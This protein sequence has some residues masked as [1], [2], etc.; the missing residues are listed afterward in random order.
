MGNSCKRVKTDE[1]AKKHYEEN[2]NK[3]DEENVEQNKEE[4]NI[5]NENVSKEK[6]IVEKNNEIKKEE[7]KEKEKNE[8]K[9]KKEE[10]EEKKNIKIKEEKENPNNDVD[11]FSEDEST[12]NLKLEIT[13]KKIQ[14]QRNHT[15]ELYEY[16]NS[17]KLEKKKIAQTESKAPSNGKDI[18]FEEDII[19]PFH[20]SQNQPLEFKI[21]D[22]I[23]D[24]VISVTLGQ[25]VGSLR[26]TY[27]ETLESGIIFEVTAI[28]NDEL[29]KECVFN[30][31][32]SGA[33]VG[34]KLGYLITSLGNQYDP[35]NK[36]VYESEILEN[37]NLVK[38]NE[39][40]IPLN[41]LAADNNLDDNIIEIELKDVL[42]SIELGKY[43]NSINQLFVKDI[44]LD[45][46]G[47][48]K[49]KIVCRKK[50]FHSLLDYLE[51]DLHLATTIFID[52]SES[53]GA[54]CHHV[55]KNESIFEYLMRS[56]LDV[57]EPY[58]EDQ[59]FHIYGYGFKLKEP[60]KKEYDP[61]MFPLSQKPDYPSIS[62]KEISKLYNDFLK[63]I[64]FDKAKT[65]ID[66]IIKKFNGTIK[67]D[68]ENYDIRDYNILLI[69]AN[70]DIT[71]EK[72]FVKNAIFTSTLPISI[73]VVGL[74]KGPYT[75]IENIEQNFLNLVDDEGNKPQRKCIKFI[76][77]NK[78]Q[79]NV[80]ST[81]K[82]S[83]IDIPEEMIEYL[84]IKNIEPSM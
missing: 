34:M 23:E 62:I 46:T 59:F 21:K 4:K 65:N 9:E 53:G 83:L 72:E 60:K 14:N 82:N 44:D 12:C 11:N 10:K 51:R 16:K 37:N 32:I 18:T 58:N 45:L 52:F 57:L 28:L 61:Y 27:R 42:H 56:F 49:A 17:R 24:T 41:Q 13:L 31:E 40:V 3:Y 73:I 30:V 7:K 38:F 69:F 71:D 5:K 25:I 6:N 39:S 36:L 70:N 8:E 78:Q 84:G 80:Q 81:V 20:F 68:I 15:I 47:N 33:L 76:S 19:I 64:N 50:N 75:K 22:S 1:K 26:Q 54:N 48:K 35:V 66:L 67:E 74:G 63:A 43:K 77:F 55:V 79:K 2:K 29:N